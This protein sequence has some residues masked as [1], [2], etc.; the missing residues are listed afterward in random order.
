M[1]IIKEIVEYYRFE[2]YW[3]YIIGGNNFWKFME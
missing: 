3:R 1:I 2:S